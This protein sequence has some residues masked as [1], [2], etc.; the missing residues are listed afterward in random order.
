MTRTEILPEGLY[1]STERQYV[2]AVVADGSLYMS[3]Q[4]AT[5]ADGNLVGD[6]IE[7]QTRQAFEN[8]GHILEEVGVGF[9]DVVKVTSYLA[10]VQADYDGYKSVFAE[11]FD[12]PLPCHTMLGIAEL[13]LEGALVEIEVEVV[14]P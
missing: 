13:A 6:D 7:T 8:V 3:G 5:D 9:E 4:I 1:D 11:F 12:D 10:E 14:L 2:H